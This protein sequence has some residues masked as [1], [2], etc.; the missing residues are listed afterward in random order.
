MGYYASF[1]GEITVKNKTDIEN[2]KDMIWESG[3]FGDIWIGNNPL[4]IQVSGHE[5]YHDEELMVLY[6]MISDKISEAEIEF[7]GEDGTRWKHSFEEGKWKEYMGRTVYDS[8]GTV[9]CDPR[10]NEE[11]M[12]R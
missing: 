9:F 12:E 8:D 3:L 1:S 7:E 10:L 11:Q 6:D 4:T 5:K 2:V